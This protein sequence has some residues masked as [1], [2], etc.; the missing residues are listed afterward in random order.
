[1]IKKENMEVT[2]KCSK[3]K[4]TKNVTEYYKNSTKSRGINSS[5]I[6]CDKNATAVKQNKKLQTRLDEHNIDGEIWKIVPGFDNYEASNLGR[7]RNIDLKKLLTPYKS[8]SSYLVC[9]LTDGNGKRFGKIC[10][11]SFW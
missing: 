5:C 3:C 11:P 7:I 4:V 10:D 6:E 2:K 8:D 9:N 1:M